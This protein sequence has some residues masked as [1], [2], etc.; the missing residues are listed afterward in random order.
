MR[1]FVPSSAL[2][3]AGALVWSCTV[4]DSDLLPAGG[5][6]S[7]AGNDT[8]AGGNKGGA[9]TNAGNSAMPSAGKASSGGTESGEGGAPGMTSGG[10]GAVASEG[11]AGNEA[12][13]AS[14]GSGGAV[15]AGSGGVAGGAGKAGSGGTGGS[16]PVVACADHPIS[17]KTT[18]VAT[19]SSSSE[20]NGM[21]TDGLFNPPEH[22]IDG[23]FGE[24]WSSGKP[25]LGD[26]WIQIDF[27]VV[28]N[29]S[30]V[31]LNVN[32]DTGDYPRKYAVRVSNKSQDFAAPVRASGDGM[33][34]N[35]VVSLASPVTGRYLTVR[36]T[37]MNEVNVTAWWTIAEVLV[38]CAD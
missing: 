32:N 3:A 2:L 11:G 25:Q 24:R 10:A 14:T 19:A 31:T 6:P 13:E 17:D 15:N 12:G 38:S 4:Y 30:S 37:G 21:E 9:T 27:G 16:A 34:G 5:G 35:L 8:G 28:V 33:P 7:G 22:M 26:E 23:K 18:W 29:L 36:Q 20:G 1:S